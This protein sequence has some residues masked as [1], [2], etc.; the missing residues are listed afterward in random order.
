MFAGQSV[1][2]LAFGVGALAGLGIAGVAFL[3]WRFLRP[4]GPAWLKSYDAT[5]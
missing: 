5:H 2:Q 1:N 4:A 3:S